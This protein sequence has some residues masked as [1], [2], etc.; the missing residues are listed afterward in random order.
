[1]QQLDMLFYMRRRVSTR[2]LLHHSKRIQ[3]ALARGEVFEWTCRGRV[4]ATIQPV[5][6]GGKDRACMDWVGRAR[7]AGAVRESGQSLSAMLYAD[8]G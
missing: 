3:A 8:R 4:I 6:A 7:K 2:E 5:P 1:M